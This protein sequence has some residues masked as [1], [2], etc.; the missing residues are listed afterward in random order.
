[1]NTL[2]RD[3]EAKSIFDAFKVVMD[4][5]F[6]YNLNPAIIVACKSQSQLEHYIECVSNQRL[7]EFKDFEI[8]I[9]V[10]PLKV[11]PNKR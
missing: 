10:T 5:M 7:D 3:R 2:I 9:E 4:M 1:M 11:K 6:N 8:R